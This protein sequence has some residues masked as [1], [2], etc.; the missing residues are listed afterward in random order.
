VASKYDRR[1]QQLRARLLRQVSAATRCP[2]CGGLLLT[3]G[4]MAKGDHDPP[5]LDHDDWDAGYMGLSH[6]SCNRQA[7]NAKRRAMYGEQSR[8][9]ICFVC[10]AVLTP[11][12]HAETQTCGKRECVTEY[13][14]W[15]REQSRDVG[16]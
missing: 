10:Y 6:R 4:P 1:H 7:G 11:T 5:E 15:R 2:R 12:H 13:R 16:I 3:P 8:A 14:R 9:V